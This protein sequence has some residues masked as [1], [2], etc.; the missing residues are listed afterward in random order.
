MSLRQPPWRKEIRVDPAV[1]GRLGLTGRPAATGS[2]QRFDFFACSRRIGA[3]K[4]SL[5]VRSGFTDH[6]SGGSSARFTSPVRVTTS[7]PMS[8]IV[9]ERVW[10]QTRDERPE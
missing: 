10:P 7:D 1:E 4:T 8:R 3:G 6:P 2:A 9:G 5:I